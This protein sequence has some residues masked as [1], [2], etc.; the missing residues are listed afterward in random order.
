MAKIK[1]AQPGGIV[2]PKFDASAYMMENKRRL[3]STNKEIEKREKR[4]SE[5]V[6]K[7]EKN[8]YSNERANK[9]VG[10]KTSLKKG[11]KVTKKK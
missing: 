3:D 11:G 7:K 10:K 5:A 4:I 6:K 2:K 9:V 1:K 8:S